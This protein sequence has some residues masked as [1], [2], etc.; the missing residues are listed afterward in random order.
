MNFLLRYLRAEDSF[1]DIGS[2]IGVYTLIA[3]S[4]ICTGSI[5]SFEAFPKN[6]ERLLENIRI[7]DFKQVKTF[8]IAVSQKTG[9]IALNIADGDALP[10]INSTSTENTITVP[11]NT[12]DNLLESETLSNI[13]LGKMDI[14]GAE[15]LAF[16]GAIS[17]LQKHRPQVW[18]IE[19]I[20]EA[21]QRFGYSNQDLINFLED[22]GYYLY[23]Y[24]ADTNQ[25]NRINL[26]QKHDNNV[27]L[28]ADSS[29]DFVRNRLA[30]TMLL[31]G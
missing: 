18:I 19:I 11:T 22:Y 20:G 13:T 3:A 26:E 8:E 28:I 14:E 30:N 7:N 27:L 29:V 2:N 24:N 12:I 17:L 4:K 10:F 25:I 23:H 16:K 15:I 21:S 1:L 9:M 31:S 5:Y 6:Y